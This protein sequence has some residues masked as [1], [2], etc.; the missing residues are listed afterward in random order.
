MFLAERWEALLMYGIMYGENEAIF[1]TQMKAA[2]DVIE[3][4]DG[5]IC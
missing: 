3:G 1:T 4:K 2:V 5:R